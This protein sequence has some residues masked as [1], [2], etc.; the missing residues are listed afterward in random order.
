MGKD[1][2]GEKM[3]EIPGQMANQER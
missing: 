3:A 1:S 2:C